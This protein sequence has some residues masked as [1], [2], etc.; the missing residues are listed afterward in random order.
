MAAGSSKQWLRRQ[1]KDPYV[2]AA[3]KEGFAS[4][5]AFKL[6]QIIEKHRFFNQL[7]SGNSAIVDLGAAP[8]GWSEL[9]LKK[10]KH[11]KLVAVDMLDM[12]LEG[13]HFIKADIEQEGLAQEIKAVVGEVDFLMSDCSPSLTG[14]RFT[15]QVRSEALAIVALELAGQVLKKGGSFLVKLRQGGTKEIESLVRP[16]F[17]KF[18]YEKPRAS[19]SES[20][21]VYLLAYDFI[22]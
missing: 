18:F 22:K 17:N 8:G 13:C 6:E 16:Q 7:L 10:N 21:E 1:N 9:L 19:R 15:D 5:A 11:L 2:R 20:A 12:A 4:R 3:R 14:H